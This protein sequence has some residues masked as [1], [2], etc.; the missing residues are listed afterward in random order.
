MW[1][2]LGAGSG[3]FSLALA[4]LLGPG[5][6]LYAIDRDAQRL[7]ELESQLRGRYPATRLRTLTAD[8][9]RPLGLPPLDGVVL[10][11]ALHFVPPREQRPTLALVRDALK[12]GG[13]LLLVEYNTERGNRWVPFPHAFPAWAALAGAAGF[14]D[15]R[16]LARRPS[17]FLGEIFSA[18]GMRYPLEQDGQEHQ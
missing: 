7:R 8:F 2:D 13:R 4:E 11:N 10:A 9:T 3:A 15:T 12:P 5:A 17:R 14:V 6:T 18:V 16:M 1:A